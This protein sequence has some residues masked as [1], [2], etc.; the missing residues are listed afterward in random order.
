MGVTIHYNGKLEDRARLA[1]MLDAAR[2]YCAEQRWLYRDVDERIIGHVE[3]V[4]ET[5]ETKIEI[6]GVEGTDVESFT[7][8]FPIDDTLRGILITVHPKAEP[9]WLTFNE[10]GELA[11]YMPL[12][13]L[14]EYWEMKSLFTKTQ[15]AGVET[16]IAVCD[17]LH[18]LQDNYFSGLNVYDEANYFE[19][20]DPARA[21][22][23]IG[24]LDGIMDRL[25]TALEDEESDDAD[26]ELIRGALDSGEPSESEAQS[27][28]KRKKI[29]VERGKEISR[30]DPQWKRGHGSS[31]G[32]N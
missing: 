29:K 21:E 8:L 20:G 12:N 10:A 4:V 7:Q 5:R 17:F 23:A 14:G 13:D 28:P 22:Q 1:E 9:V 31:A 2:L 3:R 18:Y 15:F 6:E 26:A 32:K 11:Y 27:K 25:Q 30:P 24:F 16:H 19:A